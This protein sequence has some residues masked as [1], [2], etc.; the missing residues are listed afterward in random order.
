MSSSMVRINDTSKII[1]KELSSKTGKTM[2]SILEEA[3]EKYRRWYLLEQHNQAYANLQEDKK[4][5]K[6]EL[7]E[8]EVWDQTLR[9]D[10]EE[11][12]PS[13]NDS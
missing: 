2:Q 10:L 9:D 5:W 11:E 7:E 3:V 13:Q 8:R 12:G 6:E 4:A 1:L